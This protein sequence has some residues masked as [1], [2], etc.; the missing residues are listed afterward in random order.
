MKFLPV[1]RSDRNEGHSRLAPIPH[2]KLKSGALPLG[3]SSRDHRSSTRASSLRRANHAIYNNRRCSR[4]ALRQCATSARSSS[5]LHRPLP[6]FFSRPGRLYVSAVIPRTSIERQERG[7]ER[8]GEMRASARAHRVREKSAIERVRAFALVLSKN[9]SDRKRR[10]CR[11][12]YFPAGGNLPVDSLGELAPLRCQLRSVRNSGS[13]EVRVNFTD[14]DNMLQTA[15]RA[16]P[17]SRMSKFHLDIATW[18]TNR[19]T[20]HQRLQRRRSF[21]PLS[22][23]RFSDYPSSSSSRG[24]VH[25][26]P[27]IVQ[28]RGQPDVRWST[29]AKAVD[30]AA[31][32]SA[33]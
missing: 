13:P 26:P 4:L 30:R 16:L 32:E 11:V 31:V 7:R 27:P 29:K 24:H 23:L 8:E 6:R 5:S 17:R 18:R 2:W 33:G 19:T 21:I 3:I 22:G 12:L 28:D 9:I 20:K 25:D 10:V 1:H 14:V 15:L